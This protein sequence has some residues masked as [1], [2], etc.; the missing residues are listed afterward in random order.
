MRRPATV[1]TLLALLALAPWTECVAQT[2]P[3]A[4]SP[5]G[6]L[7]EFLAPLSCSQSTASLNFQW[8]T[9]TDDDDCPQGQLCCYPCGIDGCNF[10]C[11]DPDRRGRCPIIP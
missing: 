9:C 8:I 4:T 7:A 6:D 11:M 10:V 3:P 2:P 1:L 5:T